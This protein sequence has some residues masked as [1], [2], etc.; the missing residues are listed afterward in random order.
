M[1]AAQAVSF[2][3]VSWNHEYITFDG[4]ANLKSI[5]KYSVMAE[6]DQDEIIADIIEKPSNYSI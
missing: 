6:I 2:G 3:D 4:Y 5:S 1:K